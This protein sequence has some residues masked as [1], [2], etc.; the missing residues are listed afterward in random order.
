M[1]D[2]VQIHGSLYFIDV[3]ILLNIVQAVHIKISYH[4]ITAWRIYI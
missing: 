2:Y 3:N 1:I 4:Y